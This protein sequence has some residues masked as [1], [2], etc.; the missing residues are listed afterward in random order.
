MLAALLGGRSVL[1]ASDRFVDPAGSDADDCSNN[2]TPCL[3]IAYAVAQATTGDT[4]HLAAGTYTGPGNQ[5]I[6]IS[7]ALT[8]AGADAATTILQYDPLTI[9]THN[10]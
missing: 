4:V 9:W 5:H 8:L 7:K 6:V 1:A 2:A 10:G 3:T